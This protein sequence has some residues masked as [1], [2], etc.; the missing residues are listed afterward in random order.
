MMVLLSCFLAQA[1][2]A[3]QQAKAYYF[4]A[5]T[6]F[7]AGNYAKTSEFLE[8]SKKL[9]G[10]SNASIE[11]LLVKT[12]FQNKNYSVA[13]NA[14]DAFYT[15][16]PSDKLQKQ[17]APFLVR[18]NDKLNEQ[19][20]ADDAKRES[21][22]QRY[23]QFIEK[24]NTHLQA[25]ENIAAIENYEEALKIKPGDAFATKMKLKT[26]KHH[27]KKVSGLCVLKGEIAVMKDDLNEGKE[28]FEKALE[29]APGDTGVIRRLAETEELYPIVAKKY[30]DIGDEFFGEFNWKKAK[31]NYNR[32]LE[33]QPENPYI[34]RKQKEIYANRKTGFPLPDFT[35]PRDGNVYGVVQIGDQT[36][37]TDNMRFVSDGSS[38]YE[39]SQDHCKQYG[40]LYKRSASWDACPKGWKLPK[41][42]E[43]EE[44]IYRRISPYEQ[45][46]FLTGE[47][48][49]FYATTGG[50]YTPEDGD[51]FSGFSF[52]SY[53]GKY[54]A[55]E[56]KVSLSV[57]NISIA[58]WKVYKKAVRQSGEKAVHDFME[59]GTVSISEF[60]EI[61]G[62]VK[63]S[64]RCL[65][66]ND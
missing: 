32:S 20:V 66:I 9:L 8:E 38:C 60:D 10:S 62:D 24:A 34:K 53:M 23:G 59:P 21:Q 58:E 40:R 30:Q 29:L 35:D 11:A 63:F 12:H 57:E 17:I 5:E 14:L 13:K 16:N 44:L 28:W 15:Y 56:S 61:N 45:Y 55:F 39:N 27:N 3:N 42:E 48:S 37:M 64:C 18:V 36:W 41:E 7:K 51:K 33:I 19:K 50:F 1:Q 26:R 49:K 2:D 4:Q 43:W 31:E 25:G 52:N 46:N 54:W 65:K 22:N 6:M 47:D